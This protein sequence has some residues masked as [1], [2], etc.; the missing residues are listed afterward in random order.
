[1]LLFASNQ[2]EE[3][4]WVWE[5]KESGRC[6]FKKQLRVPLKRTTMEVPK[7]QIATLLEHGLYSSAQML[8]TYSCSFPSLKFFFFAFEI[9]FPTKKMVAFRF[10][11]WWVNPKVAVTVLNRVVF[12]FLHLLQ[13]LNPPHTSKLRA[14]S[15]QIPTFYFYFLFQLLVLISEKFIEVL[16]LVI[17]LFVFVQVLLG[18]SF[19]R[20]REYRRAIVRDCAISF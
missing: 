13:M 10:M 3:A 17:Y 6:F 20:E 2:V 4:L 11:C 5:E 19:F 1:M 18:D 9:W 14:W 7:D 8:V 16:M 12:S 15:L